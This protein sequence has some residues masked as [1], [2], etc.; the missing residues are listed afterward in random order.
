MNSAIYSL[1]ISLALR[2]TV[3]TVFVMAVKL[4]FRQK[5][6]AAAHCAIWI[7]L[8]V[9]MLFCI[10][11]VRI[12]SPASIYN[13]MPETV[14]EVMPVPAAAS[15]QMQT[16]A[17]ETVS[18]Y[19]DV[20]NIIAL[21][22]AVGIISA[23]LWYVSVFIIHCIRVSRAERVT[24]SAS[25]KALYDVRTRLGIRN[26]IILRRGSYAH[27]TRNTVILPDGY[28]EDEQRQ[29]LLHEL[30]HYRHRDNMKLWAAVA[31]I[32]FNWFNPLVWLAF[33]QFRRDIEMYCDDSVI[34]LTDS[35][36]EYAKVLVKTASDNIRFVPGVSGV[37]NGTHEVARRVRRIAAWKKKKPVWLVT[38]AFACFTV[39]CLCL[40]DTVTEAVTSTVDVAAPPEPVE[41]VP[42]I[43]NAAAPEPTPEATPKP[44]PTPN[45]EPVT[46][47]QN[48]TAKTPHKEADVKQPEREAPRTAAVNNT[49]V[50]QPSAVADT[51]QTE[52]LPEQPS[53]TQSEPTPDAEPDAADFGAPESVS[54]NGSKETYSLEDGRTAVL[55]YDNGNLETGYII[56]GSQEESAE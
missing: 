13:A 37:A 53:D 26:E 5:L 21:V 46:Q 54:V 25:L 9:Q 8:C 36:K 18:G 52:V 24:D 48:N 45:A 23:L 29:I 12:P 15:A 2:M 41:V 34:R 33:R 42:A 30:C 43:L 19:M 3:I 50:Q 51:D 11:N 7:M 14:T 27:T 49:P 35:K 47:A 38:A 28:S 10:G 56:N 20:R 1:F 55:H 31:V 4:I 32:C 39:M 22:Y 16:A 44:E 17:E 6:S 40:T